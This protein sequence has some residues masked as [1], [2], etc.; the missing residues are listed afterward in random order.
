MLWKSSLHFI[1]MFFDRERISRR[2]SE[3]AVLKSEFPSREIEI[4]NSDAN[5][6]IAALCEKTNWGRKLAASYSSTLTGC[7]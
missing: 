1:D 6:A 3:L 5:D 2:A 4:I 7:R